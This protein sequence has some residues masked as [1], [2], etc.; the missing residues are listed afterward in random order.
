MV[1]ASTWIELLRG[2]RLPLI[3][4]ALQGL[5]PTELTS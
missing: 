4:F 5:V 1:R 3:P 2:L